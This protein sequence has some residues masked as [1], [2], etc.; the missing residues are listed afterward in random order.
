MTR[1]DPWARWEYREDRL[2]LARWLKAPR[3]GYRADLDLLTGAFT[4]KVR[5]HPVRREPYS[6][7]RQVVWM[8]P[9]V[10]MWRTFSWDEQQAARCWRKM[11]ADGLRDCRRAL[12]HA[13]AAR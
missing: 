7:R 11:V 5:W 2:E 12:H 6:G 8:G 4:V 10:E 9:P 13:K 1:P 3:R